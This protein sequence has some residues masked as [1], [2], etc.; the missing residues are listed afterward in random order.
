MTPAELREGVARAIREAL[1]ADG[2][3]VRSDI[4]GDASCVCC[5]EA[6]DAALA[7]VREAMR[8]PDLEMIMEAPRRVGTAHRESGAE[9]LYHGIWRAM[10]A[11]SPLGDAP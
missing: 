6:G 8:E 10:F 7:V 9:T 1:R 4:C 5:L 3:C 11:A 2:S